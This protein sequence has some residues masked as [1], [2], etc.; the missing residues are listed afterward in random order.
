M[1]KGIE[2]ALGTG[3]K[4][5]QAAILAQGGK[6]LPST[7]QQ[8]VRIG[9]MAR[10]P[11]KAVTRGVKTSVEGNRQFDGAQTCSKMPA[12]RSNRFKNNF[13]DFLG[14]LREIFNRYFFYITGL[15]NLI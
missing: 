2:F 6:T 4:S 7:G 9:L 8:F 5:A 14:Q 10:I 3:K 11:D 13:P 1:A 12:K 15:V